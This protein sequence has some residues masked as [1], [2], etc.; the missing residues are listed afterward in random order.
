MVNV[1]EL[2]VCIMTGITLLQSLCLL[3]LSWQS[4]QMANRLMHLQV[5]IDRLRWKEM[6]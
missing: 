3:C 1:L 4:R 5:M 6:D 2:L